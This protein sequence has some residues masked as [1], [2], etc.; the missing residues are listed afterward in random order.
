MKNIFTLFIACI[1]LAF[2]ANAQV[3]LGNSFI[4]STAGY[5]LG[6]SVSISGNGARI[7]IA[8]PGN[9]NFGTV[10]YHEYDSANDNWSM[11]L[12]NAASLNSIANITQLSGDGEYA[13]NYNSFPQQKKQSK[14][15]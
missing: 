4:G 1:C 15:S 6:K 5:E 2:T 3:Q 13:V 7:S 9:G 8:V 14:T 11:M 10:N 12:I